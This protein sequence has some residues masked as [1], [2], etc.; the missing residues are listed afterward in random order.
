MVWQRKVLYLV[1]AIFS[2]RHAYTK[3]F[4]KHMYTLIIFARFC[5]THCNANSLHTDNY[6]HVHK[7][8]CAI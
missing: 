8:I 6:V 5:V 4:T 2:P 7:V 1:D 3:F